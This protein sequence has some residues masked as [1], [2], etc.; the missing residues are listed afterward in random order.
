MMEH[1]KDIQIEKKNIEKKSNSS[2]VASTLIKYISYLIIFFGSLYFI[3]HYVFP[4]F[5]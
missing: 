5:K 2:L 4:L 1:N 3:I